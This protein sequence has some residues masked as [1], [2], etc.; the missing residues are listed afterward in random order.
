MISQLIFYASPLH[1]SASLFPVPSTL[2][3]RTSSRPKDQR[4]E[5]NRLLLPGG[6]LGWDELKKGSE[7]WVRQRGKKGNDWVI[8]KNPLSLFS[9]LFSSAYF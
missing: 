3:S 9:I 8:Y 2:L 5:G 7:G 4:Q 1:I 6:K